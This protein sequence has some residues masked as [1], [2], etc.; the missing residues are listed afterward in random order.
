MFHCDMCGACCRNIGAS[1]IY[2][3]L[4]RG[5]GVCKYL[6]ENKCS[7][8]SNRPLLCNVDKSYDAIWKNQMS[9]DEY[10]KLNYAACEELKKRDG[11]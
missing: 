10:Y 6:R 11:K 3:F 4:D 7:I 1:T 5:D 9:L 8:Y 2:S